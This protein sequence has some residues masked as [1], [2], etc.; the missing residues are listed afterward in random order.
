MAISVRSGPISNTSVSVIEFAWIG[1]LMAQRIS[2][3]IDD[4]NVFMT[5]LEAFA[6]PNARRAP[7]GSNTWNRPRDRAVPTALPTVPPWRSACPLPTTPAGTASGRCRSV[8]TRPATTEHGRATPRPWSTASSRRV[9]VQTSSMSAAGP[10]SP[11]ASSWPPAA[12]CSGWSPIHGW[13]STR[14]T[15]GWLSRWRRSRPGN[16]RAGSS[17]PSC[18]GRPGTGSTRSP[19]RPRRPGCY[20]P[21]GASRP[22]GTSTGHPTTW[23]RCCRRST[24]RCCLRGTWKA[25]TESA[26]R[27]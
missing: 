15:V 17:T 20:A 13:R 7:A 4:Q 12:G 8:R 5:G 21:A 9:P 19:G 24:G 10:G 22:S 11:P 18:P 6:D 16:P 1:V 23:R 2:V 25:A 3:V 14:G 27:R 26:R